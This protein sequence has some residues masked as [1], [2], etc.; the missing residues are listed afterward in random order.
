MWE[1]KDFYFCTCIRAEVHTKLKRLNKSK[2]LKKSLKKDLDNKSKGAIFA[3]PK[4]KNQ[5][6]QVLKNNELVVRKK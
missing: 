1:Q 2:T 6:V 4:R 5:D 3:D